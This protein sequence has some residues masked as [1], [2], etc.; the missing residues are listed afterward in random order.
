MINVHGQSVL[1]QIKLALT[2]QYNLPMIYSM[3]ASLIQNGNK[4]LKNTQGDI[5][6]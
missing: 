4:K 6:V 5:N 3:I 1:W 2:E